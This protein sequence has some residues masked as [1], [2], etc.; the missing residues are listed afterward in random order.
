MRKLTV[1]LDIRFE[2]MMAESTDDAM[3]A[4]RQV[5]CEMRTHCD[6]QLTEAL[7]AVGARDVKIGM[8]VY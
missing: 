3:D 5:M 8:V 4:V 6:E 7:V 2:D 1:H